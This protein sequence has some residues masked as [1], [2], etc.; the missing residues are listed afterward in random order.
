MSQH[1]AL[2]LIKYKSIYFLAYHIHERHSFLTSLLG[3]TK[4]EEEESYAIMM[5]LVTWVPVST[6][7]FSVAEAGMFYAYNFEVRIH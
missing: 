1:S 5:K 6:I 7:L 2:F 4:T 3:K